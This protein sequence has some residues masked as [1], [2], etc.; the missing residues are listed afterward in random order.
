MRNAELLDVPP[1]YA[2]L[3]ARA[4]ELP[5]AVKPDWQGVGGHLVG[6]PIQLAAWLRFPPAVKYM[7]VYTTILFGWLYLRVGRTKPPGEDTRAHEAVHDWQGDRYWFHVLAVTL[8]PRGVGL[9]WLRNKVSW[10][11]HTEAMAY[12]LNVV[13]GDLT[14]S[15]AAAKLTKPAYATGLTLAEGYDLIARYVTKLRAECK[16]IPGN[17]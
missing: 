17:H 1:D 4:A 12:A 11:G 8:D 5:W 10:R 3:I 9:P 13:R 16:G 2:E 6:W 14:T 7:T 15:E